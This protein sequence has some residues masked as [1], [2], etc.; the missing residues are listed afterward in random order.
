MEKELE[1]E[2][3]AIMDSASQDMKKDAETQNLEMLKLIEA[4][5]YEDNKDVTDNDHYL[6]KA[7]IHV[8]EFG[9]DDK[10]KARLAIEGVA[11]GGDIYELLGDSDVQKQF[12]NAHAIIATVH[13]RGQR[14]NGN[15]P[16]GEKE[17]CRVTILVSNAGIS[18]LARFESNPD[19]TENMGQADQDS[20]LGRVLMGFFQMTTSLDR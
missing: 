16:V 9:D 15:E 5:M 11:K 20:K 6:W 13:A 19:K 14:I 1:N 2:L 18:A 8:E 4:D 17:Q 12:S 10:W 3:R 7:I